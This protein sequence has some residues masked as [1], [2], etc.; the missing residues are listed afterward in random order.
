MTPELE[1]LPELSGFG[2]GFT[3]VLV[4]FWYAGWWRVEA[5]VL[6]LVQDVSRG[7]VSKVFGLRQAIEGSELLAQ[8]GTFLCLVK[9]TL[10]LHECNYKGVALFGRSAFYPPARVTLRGTFQ[11]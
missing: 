2:L 8:L 10:K 7:S 1:P 3:C 11:Q 6:L 9:P 4:L 5:I